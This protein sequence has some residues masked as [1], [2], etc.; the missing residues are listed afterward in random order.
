MVPINITKQ[1][2]EAQHKRVSS[3]CVQM[4]YDGTYEHDR[5]II[6]FR[7]K[8]DQ[9]ER[10]RRSSIRVLGIC[11]CLGL[12]KVV[13]AVALGTRKPCSQHR[14]TIGFPFTG[15]SP[16]LLTGCT[17]GCP[18][19]YMRDGANELAVKTR[20]GDRL[21]RAVARWETEEIQITFPLSF[22]F[23]YP[24]MK[25]NKKERER[26]KLTVR[27]ARRV[28]GAVGGQTSG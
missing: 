3:F 25:K 17:K 12:V 5:S 20:M 2:G 19:N 8:P 7:D 23:L 9:A 24:R 22:L 6:V 10:E 13:P 27:V 15:L 28:R 14:D 16:Y 26:E 21:L 1:I 18:S 11:D 4:T